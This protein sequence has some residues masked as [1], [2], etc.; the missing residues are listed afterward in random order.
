MDRSAL[1][2]AAA[3]NAT[4]RR[5]RF[6]K[7][8]AEIFTNQKQEGG[9]VEVETSVQLGKGVNNDEWVSSIGVKVLGFPKGS[10]EKLKADGREPIFTVEITYKGVYAWDILP[11]KEILTD[12][13]LAYALGRPLYMVAAAEC[14]AA[15]AK[16]GF[17][18]VS[19][20]TDLAK[21][22]EGEVV[23]GS[24]DD[25]RR[26][27]TVLAKAKKTSSRSAAAKKTSVS[28]RQ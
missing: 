11:S 1:I 2:A 23:L 4:L 22:S 14:R 25:L 6:Q 27:D 3:L 13:D 5:S 28:R 16:L 9:L 7:I 19:I 17:I 8:F 18:G 20:P 26:L 21:A 24:P 12:P 10:A 15:A